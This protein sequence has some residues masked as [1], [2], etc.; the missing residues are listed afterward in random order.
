MYV[1]LRH[2]IECLSSLVMLY[3]FAKEWRKTTTPTTRINFR[4]HAP[5]I[6]HTRISPSS[7]QLLLSFWKIWFILSGFFLFLHNF[8]LDCLHFHIR[9]EKKRECACKI[10]KKSLMHFEACQEEKLVSHVCKFIEIE[11]MINSHEILRNYCIFFCIS[12]RVVVVVVAAA[13]CEICENIEIMMTTRTTFFE[14][15][16][17]KIALVVELWWR[18]ESAC[19]QNDLRFMMLLLI[20]RFSLLTELL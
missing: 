9:N 6:S 5:F 13:V 3:N 10:C 18:I 15:E 17:G 4:F 16:R 11:R 12:S 1:L 19:I 14:R 20:L 8:F 7:C 2:Y